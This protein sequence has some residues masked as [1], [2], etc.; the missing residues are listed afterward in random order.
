MLPRPSQLGMGNGN[1]VDLQRLYTQTWACALPVRWLHGLL[2]ASH[3][4]NYDPCT[5][6]ETRRS[7]KVGIS[8]RWRHI[9]PNGM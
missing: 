9:V 3:H 6:M 7:N 5:W 4:L 8:T 1:V 2:M